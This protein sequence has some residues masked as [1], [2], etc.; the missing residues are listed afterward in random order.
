MS[1]QI[2]APHPPPPRFVPDRALPPYRYVPGQHP[3][4]FRHPD[5]HMYTDGGAPEEP[6]WDANQSGETDQ[7]FLWG[8]DLFNH[9]YYWEAHEA[10]EAIWHRVDRGEPRSELFQGLIQACAFVLQRHRGMD[11]PANRLDSVSVGRLQGVVER[12]G[13]VCYGVQLEETMAR[14]TA[15]AEGGDWPQL[16]LRGAV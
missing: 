11:K 4:P 16:S 8:V 12:V 3:H 1:R 13:V 14:L 6:D 10:W 2:P 15:F 9:R 7:A 5:G